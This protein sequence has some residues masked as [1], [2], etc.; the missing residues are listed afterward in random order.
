MVG[1]WREMS[2]WLSS[3]YQQLITQVITKR[4][5]RLFTGV[6]VRF[7]LLLGRRGG[8]GIVFVLGCRQTFI[9]QFIHSVIAVRRFCW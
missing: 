5:F 7:L 9:R 2:H 1:L 8:G 4:F 3:A 6:G